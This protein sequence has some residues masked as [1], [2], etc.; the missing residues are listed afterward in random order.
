M[1]LGPNLVI[2]AS[3][4]ARMQSLQDNL[5]DLA[6]IVPMLVFLAVLAALLLGPLRKIVFGKR[7]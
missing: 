4:A 3:W 5:T 6:S 7:P 2:L 1:P